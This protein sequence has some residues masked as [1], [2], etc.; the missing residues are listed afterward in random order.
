MSMSW[1]GVSA[2]GT[3]VPGVLVEASVMWWWGPAKPSDE[4][5]SHRMQTPACAG[6]SSA[7]V[8]GRHLHVAIAVVLGP[9]G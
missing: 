3:Q 5:S 4:D 9:V 2:A 6:Q 1:M 7:V 8:L